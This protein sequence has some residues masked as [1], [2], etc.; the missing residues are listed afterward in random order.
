MAAK[1]RKLFSEHG[2][3][4]YQIALFKEARKRDLS[5]LLA[6]N[7]ISRRRVGAVFEYIWKGHT[8]VILRPLDGIDMQLQHNKATNLAL[9]AKGIDGVVIQPGE[10][11]SFWNLVGDA[12]ARKGYQV[13]LIITGSDKSEG[14]GGGLCQ[15]ANLIHYMVLHTPL[16]IVELHHHSDALFPDA[17]RRVPFGTGTSV[18]Y[19]HIDYRFKNTTQHPVQLKIWVDDTMLCGEIRGV[20]PLTQKYRLVEENSHYVEEDGVY[21]RVSQ[22][23]RIIRDVASGEETKELI[24]SNHSRV[25]YD[26]SLIPPDEIAPR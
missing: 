23:Y 20:V 10:I 9:A 25:M 24:L 16:T 1:R 4:F 6:H 19:K 26:Y 17:G 12:T 7:K 8:S 18:A 11:F 22:V 5:D 14:I 21:F 3:V 13:G 15:L 2:P